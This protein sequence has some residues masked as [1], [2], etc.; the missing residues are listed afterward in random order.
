MPRYLWH[1]DSDGWPLERIDTLTGEHVP[2]LTVSPD[3]LGHHQDRSR[4]IACCFPRLGVNDGRRVD[5]LLGGV[6]GRRVANRITRGFTQPRNR[7]NRI[8]RISHTSKN[9]SEL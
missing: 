7:V 5:L 6:V 9:R 1:L 4:P 8:W 3:E 2:V